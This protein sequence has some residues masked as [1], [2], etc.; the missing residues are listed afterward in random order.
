MSWQFVWLLVGAQPECP[1]MDLCVAPGL[2]QPG[3]RGLPEV[4]FQEGRRPV[5]N[6]LQKGHSAMSTAFCWS[7]SHRTHPSQEGEEMDSSS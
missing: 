5:K 3:G 7:R 6:H 1:L 2:S 4:A